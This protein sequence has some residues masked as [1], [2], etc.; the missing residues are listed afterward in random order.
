MFVVVDGLAS[1]L[2]CK[3]ICRYLGKNEHNREVHGFSGFFCFP[4]SFFSCIEFPSQRAT[5]TVM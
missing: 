2:A 1:E 3:Q 5:G 4:F